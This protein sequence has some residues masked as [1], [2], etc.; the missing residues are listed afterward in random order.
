MHLHER[1]PDYT[2]SSTGYLPVTAA[3][4]LQTTS[5]VAST[6]WPLRIIDAPHVKTRKFS[7]TRCHVTEIT[8]M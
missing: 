3:R 4:S 6:L 5:V 1:T 8:C 2:S 7:V